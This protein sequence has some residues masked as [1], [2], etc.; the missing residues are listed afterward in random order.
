MQ[1][2]RRQLEKCRPAAARA[3]P[4]GNSSK[5]ARRRF[6][7]PPGQRR[8]PVLGDGF[9]RAR[10]PS[11][12]PHLDRTLGIHLLTSNSTRLTVRIAHRRRV[13]WISLLGFKLLL[14]F[15]FQADARMNPFCTAIQSSSSSLALN[16]T[17]QSRISLIMP[18][19]FTGHYGPL[20]SV[21]SV[22]LV[23][24]ACVVLNPHRRIR[25][26]T[27]ALLRCQSCRRTAV[28]P[29]EQLPHQQARTL[30]PLQLP[31]SRQPRAAATASSPPWPPYRS[32]LSRR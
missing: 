2:D 9:W 32:V 3:R 1:V 7:A 11:R 17:R 31:R 21:V 6:A 26:D 18:A 25:E 14:Y 12:A 10:F 16:A 28:S 30:P 22:L 24:S 27:S 5:A 13:L 29:P 15:R 4:R 20:I 23:S 19:Q 8:A